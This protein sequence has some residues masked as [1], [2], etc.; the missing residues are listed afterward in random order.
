MS[1]AAKGLFTCSGECARCG[2]LAAIAIPNFVSMQYKAKR[3]EIPMNLKA[4]KVAEVSYEM[5]YDVYIPATQW[6]QENRANRQHSG[7][8]EMKALIRSIFNHRVMFVGAIG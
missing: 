7:Y 1:S 5:A 4:I 6:P 8:E 2:I 3:S